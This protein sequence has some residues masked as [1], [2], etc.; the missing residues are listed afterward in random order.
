MRHRVA[1]RKFDRNSG[2][3]KALF[4]NM[5]T[6]L[7]KHDR[8][9]TTLSR[10]KEVR[11]IAEKLITKAKK[12]DLHSR[13][14]VRKIVTEKAAVKRLFDIIIAKLSGKNSGG[15]TR[16]IKLGKR[17]KGDDA[18]LAL[19]E[20]IEPGSTK[21]TKH[22][23]SSKKKP[24]ARRKLKPKKGEDLKIKKKPLTEAERKGEIK[25]Q[26]TL[27][28]EKLAEEGKLPTKDKKEPPVT[29]AATPQSAMEAGEYPSGTEEMGEKPS[30]SDKNDQETREGKEEEAGEPEK[31]EGE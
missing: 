28:A 9:V 5:V 24:D 18:S 20:I 11:S 6:Q 4:R 12:E 8:I 14:Q 23:K 3:R 2:A 19:L 13:R 1:G 26:P 15:Y 31:K 16:I 21:K 25:T 7:F 29:E 10:A 30:I 27:G 17:R 22:P